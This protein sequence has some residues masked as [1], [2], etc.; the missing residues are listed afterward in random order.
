MGVTC[1]ALLWSPTL[2]PWA[3]VLI[4]AMLFGFFYR[5]LAE[6]VFDAYL[7]WEDWAL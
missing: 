4:V 3:V 5:P 2:V 6:V 7:R 1:R